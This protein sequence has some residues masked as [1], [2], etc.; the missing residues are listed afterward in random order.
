MHIMTD[1]VQQA[2]WKAGDQF[3]V[4]TRD[5]NGKTVQ[6]VVVKLHVQL[7]RDKRAAAPIDIVPA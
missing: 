3:N 4:A 5:Q 6:M 2:S 1:P 7:G